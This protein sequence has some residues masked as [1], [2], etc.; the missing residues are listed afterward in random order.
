MPNKAKLVTRS[1]ATSSVT[2]DN[3]NKGSA[4]EFAELDSSLINLRDQTFGI[5]ADDSST[6]D[7]GAGDTLYIQGGTNVTT[8]TNSDGSI[9]INSSGGGGS[10][11][12]GNISGSGDTLS[13]S[14]STINI[15]DP[16]SISVAGATGSDIGNIA[17]FNA[18][19]NLVDFNHQGALSG[20]FRIYDCLLYTSPSPRDSDSSRMPS[21]A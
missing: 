13:S 21:S 15:N 19:G 1:T 20:S 7:I 10:G 12:L 14:G 16:L 11:S 3:L 8:S 5:V 17:R 6:I 18:G 2:A 9:T 4:L